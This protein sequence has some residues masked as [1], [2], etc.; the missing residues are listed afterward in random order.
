MQIY[1][2][3]AFGVTL[4]EKVCCEDPQMEMAGHGAGDGDGSHTAIAGSQQGASCH[5]DGMNSGT[6]PEKS[7]RTDCAL[8]Q[9]HGRHHEETCCPD[10]ETLFIAVDADNQ[11]ER[12]YTNN[13]VLF[14]KQ[15]LQAAIILL[16]WIDPYPSYLELAESDPVRIT[17][18][19]DAPSD[20]PIFIRDCTYRI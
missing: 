2:V 7:D 10:C 12:S 20:I 8:C 18:S 4:G 1:M 19:P 16:P 15:N 17:G 11:L 3:A 14:S 9:E 5:G 6:S 13:T